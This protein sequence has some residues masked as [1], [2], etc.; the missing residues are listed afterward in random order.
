MKF[1]RDTRDLIA[2]IE[3]RPESAAKIAGMD[4]WERWILRHGMGVVMTAGL[5]EW[6]L[7][8][9]RCI[10]RYSNHEGRILQRW[11]FEGGPDN[12]VMLIKPSLSGEGRKKKLTRLVNKLAHLRVELGLD[13]KL[14][15]AVDCS[16]TIY[17][18]TATI[19]TGPSFSPPRKSR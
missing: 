13:W 10:V 8:C 14:E 9:L 4:P 3:E 16:K 1:I 7:A 15:R 6:E 11:L 2:R 19:I 12:D 18:A 5:D 17:T